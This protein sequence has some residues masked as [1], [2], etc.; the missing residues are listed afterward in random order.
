M[1]E[2]YFFRTAACV[3][4]FNLSP[5]NP[6]TSQAAIAKWTPEAIEYLRKCLVRALSNQARD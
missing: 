3:R 5:V 1:N 6:D 4:L 2:P